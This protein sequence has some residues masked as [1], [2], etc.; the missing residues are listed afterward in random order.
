M[1]RLVLAIISLICPI[2]LASCQEKIEWVIENQTVKPGPEGEEEEIIVKQ[3]GFEEIIALPAQQLTPHPQGGD[4]WGN[5]FFQFVT[6][7][8]LVRVYDLS[9]KTLVQTVHIGSSQRGFV[10]NCHCNTVCFGN[11]YYDAEDIFPLI[12]VSTGYAAGDY[13]G[14]LVYRITQHN[15][16]FFIT[17][18]QTI[19]FPVDK[20]SWTEFIPGDDGFAYL[21]YTTERVIFKVTL[22]KIKDGDITITRDEVRVALKGYRPWRAIGYRRGAQ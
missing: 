9:T 11:E 20:S 12:Y 16:L 7:N 21:C 22:P 2:L 13:T 6:N 5:Y 15:D 18:V 8:S 14:A 17:L 3:P 10:P 4:S 1:K 19:R